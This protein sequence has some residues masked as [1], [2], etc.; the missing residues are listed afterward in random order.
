MGNAG[1][2]A[3][4]VGRVHRR[5]GGDLYF[6]YDWCRTWWRH[7]GGRYQLRVLLLRRDGDLVGLLPMMIDR[8]WLGP[9]RLRLA[10][11]VGSEFTTAV[12]NPPVVEE[13][14]EAVYATALEY[15]LN[16]EHC[17]AVRLGPLVGTRPH[18][19]QIRRVCQASGAG[20]RLVRDRD[21]GV[22][23]VVDLPETYEAYLAGLG[24]KYRGTARRIRR[25]LEACVTPQHEV[26]DH[27]SQAEAAFEEFL[28]MHQ[29]RWQ[30][31]GMPGHFGEFPG[32]AAFHRDMVRTMARQCRLWMTRLRVDG[33][34]IACEYNYV[35][36]GVL[37]GHLTARRTGEP[38]EHLNVGR[39][40]LLY[41]FEACMQ[42]GIRR[43]EMGT[44]SYPYKRELGGTE[45]TVGLMVIAADRPWAAF[46]SGP[47]LRLHWWLVNLLYVRVWYRHIASRLPTWLRGPLRGFWL[48]AGCSGWPRAFLLR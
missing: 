35:L 40:S 23:G 15:L 9:V 39:V 1:A 3:K 16:K 36:H 13:E 2:N 42:R 7:Y 28:A 33:Q 14:A 47:L 18:R 22:H 30:A 27:P 12:L 25:N 17:D 29:A 43:I 26:V 4:G 44:G 6:A 48:R 10:K 19:E 45:A 31:D 20:V 21:L 46:K 11:L 41:L 38:W 24:G 8:M 34:T 37:Y 32:A 5:S